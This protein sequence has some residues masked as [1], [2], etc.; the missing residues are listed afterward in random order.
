MNCNGCTQC[1]H[2]KEGGVAF[3]S[4]GSILYEREGG[5]LRDEEEGEISQVAEVPSI[6]AQYLGRN[7][8]RHGREGGREG[9]ASN[10]RRAKNDNEVASK[11]TTTTTTMN[12]RVTK[13]R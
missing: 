12:G 7:K 2:C 8:Q 3:G 13:K 1:T 11:T 9:T 5:R 4:D 6:P 10:S